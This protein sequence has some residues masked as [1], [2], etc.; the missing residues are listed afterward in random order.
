MSKQRRN[1]PAQEEPLVGETI[2][3]PREY[4]LKK[5]ITYKGKDKVP[6]DKVKLNDRQAEWLKG[7]EH[8]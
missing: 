2:T 8:I 4:T 5:P 6:G 1:L 7:S 3:G